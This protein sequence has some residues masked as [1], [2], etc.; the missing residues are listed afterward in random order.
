MAKVNFKYNENTDDTTVK[1]DF[2]DL[3]TIHKLDFLSDCLGMLTELYNAE[4]KAWRNERRGHN[5]RV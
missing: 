2:G 1:T 5:V 3:E 4:L